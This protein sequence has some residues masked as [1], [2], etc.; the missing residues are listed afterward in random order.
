MF[1]IYYPIFQNFCSVNH[2]ALIDILLSLGI[3]PGLD[4]GEL[5][6]MGQVLQH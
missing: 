3:G 4:F 2:T 6:T 1:N 5:A